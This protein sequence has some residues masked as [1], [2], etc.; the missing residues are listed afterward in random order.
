MKSFGYLSHTM[1]SKHATHKGNAAVKSAKKP[2][3]VTAVKFNSPQLNAKKA[4][5][6]SSS[7]QFYKSPSL[8]TPHAKDETSL[9]SLLKKMKQVQS[10]AVKVNEVR[11]EIVQKLQTL[12]KLGARRGKN[13]TLG[14]NGIAKA[15]E[16]PDECGVAVVCIAGEGKGELVHSLGRAAALRQVPVVVIPKFAAKLKE[17][18]A[19]KQAFCFALRTVGGETL[20][21]QGALDDFRE[22]LTR[23]AQ[24]KRQLQ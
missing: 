2:S 9:G 16:S 19:V 5:Q 15:L 24:S 14:F 3:L 8:S 6:S 11:D 20:E 1:K 23:V 10:P 22:Y 18:F 13:F 12:Q 4:A 21:A 7:L 17:V